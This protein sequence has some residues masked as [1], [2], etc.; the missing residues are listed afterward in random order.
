MVRDIQSFLNVRDFQVA[1]EAGILDQKSVK[2]IL[3]ADT[4][5]ILH[6]HSNSSLQK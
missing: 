6:R 2:S 3:A 4:S 1:I 5:A